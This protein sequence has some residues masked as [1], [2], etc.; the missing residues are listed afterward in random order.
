MIIIV[1][2]FIGLKESWSRYIKILSRKYDIIGVMIHDP[3]DYSMPK[4]AGQYLLEDPYSGDK[5]YVDS[6]Q[7][8]KIY[9]EEVKKRV[10]YVQNVFEKAKM[11]FVYLK[12]NKDYEEPI[13]NFFRRRVVV[14]R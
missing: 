1:S 13:V 6:A 10:D 11:G 9:A 2:D 5:I 4:Q 12:T 7:Y 8:R 14:T 3:R